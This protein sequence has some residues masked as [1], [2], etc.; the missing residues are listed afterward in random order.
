MEAS[1]WTALTPTPASARPSIA[2]LSARLHPLSATCT[3]KTP[4]V[5]SMI[6][7]T[8]SASNPLSPLPTTSANVPQ[9]TQVQRIS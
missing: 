9:A 5:S 2:A 8:E 7:S 3:S 4:L 1:V 6:A